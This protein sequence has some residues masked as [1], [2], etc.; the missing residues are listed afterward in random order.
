MPRLEQDSN[1]HAYLNNRARPKALVDSL[2]FIQ[3]EQYTLHGANYSLLE[4]QANEWRRAGARGLSHDNKPKNPERSEEL[5]RPNLNSMEGFMDFAVS[6]KHRADKGAVLLGNVALA[7]Y[8]T[9]RDGAFSPS[10]FRDGY[11]AD[12]YGSGCPMLL[13]PKDIRKIPLT[14][15]QKTALDVSFQKDPTGG[16]ALKNPLLWPHAL[17]AAVLL[18]EPES[19]RD[20]MKKQIPLFIRFAKKALSEDPKAAV[21][22]TE[23][24]SILDR[25]I[26]D[27]LGDF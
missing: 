18:V 13:P 10:Q 9:H 15:R 23:R 14:D 25:D 26:L 22:Y 2:V 19:I 7:L 24:Q 8:N 1:I 17:L 20:D 6:E 27:A 3:R 16:E 5:A 11:N 12:V 4:M 21:P